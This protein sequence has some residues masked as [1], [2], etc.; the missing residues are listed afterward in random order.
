[1]HDVEKQAGPM[2]CDNL[3]KS[4]SA[5]GALLKGVASH[6]DGLGDRFLGED[7]GHRQASHLLGQTLSQC[8]CKTMQSLLGKFHY[9]SHAPELRYSP[10]SPGKAGLGLESPATPVSELE[11]RT[12]ALSARGR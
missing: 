5:T 9:M 4:W 8:Y 1:M 12:L 7:N 11:A 10:S 2:I 3:T 6:H